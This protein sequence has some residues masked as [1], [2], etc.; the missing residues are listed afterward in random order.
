MCICLWPEFDCPEV[1][2]C[3]WQDTKIQLLLLLMCLHVHTLAELSPA[4]HLQMP[5][6]VFCLLCEFYPKE[7]FLSDQAAVARQQQIQASH[8]CQRVID[9]S[10]L[11]PS[12]YHPTSSLATETQMWVAGFVLEHDACNVSSET[13]GENRAQKSIAPLCSLSGTLY[14]R[15][16]GW[17]VNKN[18]H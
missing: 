5:V 4:C 6:C 16:T 14:P 10:M 15:K 8:P 2:L 11:A 3:G 1:T 18:L 17:G 13:A 12:L 7:H 9:R